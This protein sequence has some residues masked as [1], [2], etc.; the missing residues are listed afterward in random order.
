MAASD[1]FIGYRKGIS[2]IKWVDVSNL[3]LSMFASCMF[4]KFTDG[5]KNNCSENFANFKENPRGGV[6]LGGVILEEQRQGKD[7]TNSTVFVIF[8]VLQEVALRRDFSK[9]VFLKVSKYSQESTFVGVS[10]SQES[11]CV[12]VSF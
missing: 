8:N 3:N 6:V 4:Q 9:Y 11:T 1:A 10:F 5:L 12:G 7:S 2:G